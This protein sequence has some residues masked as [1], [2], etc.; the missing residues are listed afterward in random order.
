MPSPLKLWGIEDTKNKAMI[1]IIVKFGALVE[2]N[3][4]LNAIII[5]T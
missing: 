3:E 5:A 2:E 1:L 4:E